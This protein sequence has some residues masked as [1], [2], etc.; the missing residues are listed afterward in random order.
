MNNT[1]KKNILFVCATGI[2]TS[3]VAEEKT[4]DYLHEHGADADYVQANVSS[5]QQYDTS[6]ID[7][8]VA[9]TQV[10][11]DLGVPVINALPLI[12]GV[13]A[14]KVLENILKEVTEG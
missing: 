3:T 12:T 10:P 8:V 11:Y 6:S 9:T 1:K 4:M 2:A 7:L 5:L 14:E 13:G